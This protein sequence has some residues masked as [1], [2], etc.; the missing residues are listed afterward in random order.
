VWASNLDLVLHQQVEWNCGNLAAN[1]H[2][3]N[4]ANPSRCYAGDQIKAYV[5]NF[6]Y[7]MG[8]RD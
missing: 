1:V 3:L 4:M 7:R 5:L 6:D 8:R 2:M